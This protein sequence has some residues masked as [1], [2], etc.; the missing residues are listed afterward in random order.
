MASL[1]DNTKPI[2]GT[3]TTAS[4]RD[5]FTV[6]K[7]EITT[8]QND[9]AQRSGDLGGTSASTT[10]T[11]IQNRD[12]ASAPVPANTQPL[13]WN[14]T[15][16]AASDVTQLQGRA[17]S[18]TAPTTGQ[19]L[20]W[21]GTAWAPVS[22]TGNPESIVYRPMTPDLH[23]WVNAEGLFAG[24][25]SA[26]TNAPDADFWRYVGQVSSAGHI[27]LLAFSDEKNRLLQ[28][29]CVGGTWSSWSEYISGRPTTTATVATQLRFAV[30]TH[31]N[32]TIIPPASFIGNA[33]GDIRASWNLNVPE[34]APNH[35]VS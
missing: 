5:N 30:P 18:T 31:Q 4:V 3:P 13:T 12:I 34:F 10:V 15:A 21:N 1:I 6:A 8:L 11:R 19:A 14:G 26:I 23:N 2:S 20:I 35:T 27:T 9:K 29:T 33:L 24:G 16:W 7:N 22:G 32:L 28:K 17:V 25:G